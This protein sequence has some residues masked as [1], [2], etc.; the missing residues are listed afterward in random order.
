MANGYIVECSVLG[1][2]WNEFDANNK[3]TVAG[4]GPTFDLVD[5]FKGAFGEVSGIV[6]VFDTTS[7]WNG[8]VN[9]GVKFKHEFTTAS[10]K[11]GV[12]YS[13]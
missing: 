8:F 4:L 6:N 10:I 7:R 9:G 1:K 12:R 5:N 2:I 13:W 11:G 3:L